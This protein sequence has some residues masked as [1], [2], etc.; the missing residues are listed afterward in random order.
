MHVEGE[1]PL[2][3]DLKIWSPVFKTFLQR[4]RGANG[5]ALLGGARAA[6]PLWRP[7]ATTIARH[8]GSPRVLCDA[9]RS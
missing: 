5:Y 6:H 9:V 2:S 7:A 4:S 1:K 8:P 3:P